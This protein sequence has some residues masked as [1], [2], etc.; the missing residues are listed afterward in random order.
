ME[1]VLFIAGTV[2][3]FALGVAYIRF[4]DRIIGPDPAEAPIVGRAATGARRGGLVTESTVA[5]VL[6]GALLVYLVLA[7]VFPEKF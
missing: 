1:D 3:F 4:C 2:G 5:L 7:L 6:A